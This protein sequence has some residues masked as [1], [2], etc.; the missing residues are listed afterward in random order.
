MTARQHLI[1][2]ITALL[3]VVAAVAA[4]AIGAL[5]VPLSAWWSMI[6][7]GEAHSMGQQAVL[8]VVRLPRVL[9]A[10]LAGAGLA[11]G[12]AA[13]QALFRNPLADP[14]II[15]ISSGAGLLAAFAIVAAAPLGALLGAWAGMVTLP[16]LAFVGAL[17]SAVLVFGIARDGVRTSVGAMLLAG[18]G[19]T[20]I[21]GA[22]TGL[23]TYTA[24]NDQLRSI[25]FWMLG[26]LG[27]ADRTAITIMLMAVP[28]PLFLVM[29]SHRALNALVLGE[30]QARYLGIDPERVKR[31]MI[32]CTAFMVGATVALCGV[33]GFL[34]LVVPHVLRMLGGADNRFLLPASALAGALLLVLADTIARTLA[35]P[36]EIPIGVITAL[37]GAPVFLFLLVRRKRSLAL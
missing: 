24:S 36:A 28:V 15:G 37:C 23:L 2:L 11:T 6:T 30:E 16:V 1:L 13:M 4:A 12:G 20:A 31:R 25:T 5:Y 18:I 14:S 22:L 27:G 10:L 7:G 26:S 8:W 9:L 32:V 34:G 17:T 19:I 33:I 3:L 29:R 21:T 35:A